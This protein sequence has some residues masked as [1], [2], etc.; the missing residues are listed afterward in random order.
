ME[1]QF[2]FMWRTS[3]SLSSWKLVKFLRNIY[4]SSA[5]TVNE[6]I[7]LGQCYAIKIYNALCKI[8]RKMT[9]NNNT[10]NKT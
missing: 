3:Q 2:L 6:P 9:E 10:N 8:T 4:S 1:M 5:I 7:D